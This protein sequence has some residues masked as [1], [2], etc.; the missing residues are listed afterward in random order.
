M[1]LKFSFLKVNHNFFLFK[2]RINFYLLPLIYHQD[3]HLIF[4]HSTQDSLGDLSFLILWF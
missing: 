1:R 3:P 4:L 2:I